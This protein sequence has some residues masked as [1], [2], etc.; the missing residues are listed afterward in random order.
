MSIQS[1]LGVLSELSEGN[2][3]ATKFTEIKGYVVQ[4]NSDASKVDA[5]NAA[6]EKLEAV[7]VQLTNGNKG[8]ASV[9]MIN[10]SMALASKALIGVNNTLIQKIQP[11]LDILTRVSV[12]QVSAASQKKADAPRSQLFVPALSVSSRGNNL[13]SAEAIVTSPRIGVV[14]G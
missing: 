9:G 1:A 14:A 5:L 2:D 11:V 7:K 4:F 10:S 6:I 12:D 8:L 13:L 3:Y